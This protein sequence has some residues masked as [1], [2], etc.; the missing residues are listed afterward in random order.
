MKDALA[1]Q[2]LR[3][4]KMRHM[5]AR[6]VLLQDSG[7]D[8]EHAEKLEEQQ[9]Q[10]QETLQEHRKACAAGLPPA[11]QLRLASVIP[12]RFGFPTGDR[13]SLCALRWASRPTWRRSNKPAASMIQC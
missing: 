13:L 8:V 3:H 6:A 11:T 4:A 1:D 5:R 10:H 9:G 2:Q 7:A 12:L